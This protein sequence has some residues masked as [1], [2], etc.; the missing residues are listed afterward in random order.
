M[1]LPFLREVSQNI[2]HHLPQ[3]RCLEQENFHGQTFLKL[4]SVLCSGNLIFAPAVE[5]VV[6]H[7]NYEELN[8]RLYSYKREVLE[9]DT[10]RYCDQD[11][12][13]GLPTYVLY[14]Q[15]ILCQTELVLCQGIPEGKIFNQFSKIKKSDLILCLIEKSADN[16]GELVF[17]AR[18]CRTVYNTEEVNNDTGLCRECTDFFNIFIRNCEDGTELDHEEEDGIK[19]CPFSDCGR[20][21]R[22]NKPWENHLRSHDK[23]DD[24]VPPITDDQKRK[25]RS[26]SNVVDLDISGL[27]SEVKCEPDIFS[28]SEQISPNKKIKLE[29]SYE[30]S[31]KAKRFQC[32]ICSSSYLYEK[33]FKNH[34]QSHDTTILEHTNIDLSCEICKKSVDNESELN[35][36]MNTDHK[37]NLSCNGC[38]MKFT[39]RKVYEE[40]L[41]EMHSNICC[42]SCDMIF[43]CSDSLQSHNLEHHDI[44]SGDPCHICGKHVK[45]SSM[46]NHVKMVHHSEEMRKHLCNICG[47]AYKTK[48]DLDRHYTKHTGIYNIN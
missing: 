33:A 12:D 44:L 45:R 21:F 31:T 27:E 43:G 46:A 2:K 35:E 20:T 5:I 32:S 24:Q 38:P 28:K 47:N 11:L 3:I 41:S 29:V 13:T 8:M 14:V 10:F 6:T 19:I 15:K 17:R 4:S 48:T 39:F 7:K 36:H 9:E 30:T 25:R 18:Q 42:V 34:I 40:H 16:K 23:E 22:R 1:E 37:N 26:S